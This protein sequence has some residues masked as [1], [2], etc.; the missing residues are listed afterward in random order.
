MI[1]FILSIFKIVQTFN[2]VYQV[3]SLKICFIKSLLNQKI[4]KFNSVFL[5]NI[6][7][8]IK[9]EKNLSHLKI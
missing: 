7:M 1:N 6:V 3:Q 8:T 4:V 2:P 5:L 9:N